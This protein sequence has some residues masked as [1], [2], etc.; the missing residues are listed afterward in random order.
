MAG[1]SALRYSD[2]SKTPLTTRTTNAG[3][4]PGQL[5]VASTQRRNP[6][7][8]SQNSSTCTE[9]G[10]KA[11][12]PEEDRIILAL[13][14][15]IGPRW[16]KIVKHLNGRTTASARNRWQRIEKGRRQRE[17][18]G[19]VPHQRCSKCGLVR[20][21]H[22]CEARS[23]RDLERSD[24]PSITSSHFDLPKSRQARPSR[25]LASQL[26]LDPEDP[27]PALL[28]RMRSGVRLCSELGFEDLLHNSWRDIDASEAPSSPR[29][30]EV[31]ASIELPFVKAVPSF[32]SFN[33]C[34]DASILSEPTIGPATSCN[35]EMALTGRPSSQSPLLSLGTCD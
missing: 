30:S 24:E 29:F 23:N 3:S 13:I 2:R 31:T 25:P 9:P 1:R 34:P 6:V 18:G 33:A 8:S 27:E 21:G 32:S 35:L 10:I 28:N 20:R 11:W 19:M 7:S 17:N 16:S 26:T 5:Q 15:K 14:A 12:E 22:V 4:S